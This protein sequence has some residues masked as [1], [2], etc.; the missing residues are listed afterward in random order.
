MNWLSVFPTVDLKDLVFLDFLSH[1][2]F[3]L[4]AFQLADFVAAVSSPFFCVPM[5][6]QILEK[7]LFSVI[8]VGFRKGAK[9]D[10]F[11]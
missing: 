8:L 4:S 9:E 11:I 2:P 5:D 6:I 7:Y 1:L 10:A 3:V